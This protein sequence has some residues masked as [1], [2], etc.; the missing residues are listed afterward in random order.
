MDQVTESTG[1][2]VIVIEGTA[3]VGKTTLT[4][5]FGHRICERFPDGQLYVNMRGFDETGRP[6]SR[7]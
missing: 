1:A 3:G 4:N 5:H 6:M 2:I 7:W